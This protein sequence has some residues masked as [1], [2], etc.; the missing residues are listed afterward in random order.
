MYIP[1]TFK[2][3]SVSFFSGLNLWYKMIKYII[4]Y[5]AAYSQF[6]YQIDSKRMLPVFV[7]KQAFNG[8]Q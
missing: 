8:R 4:F 6:L 5:A 3:D 1:E 7:K 2:I